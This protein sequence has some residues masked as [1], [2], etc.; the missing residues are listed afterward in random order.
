VV[1]SGRPGFYHA[2]KLT[3]V[4]AEKV[5]HLV[6]GKNCETTLGYATQRAVRDMEITSAKRGFGG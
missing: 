3:N 5:Q 4:V 6:P 2:V 1:P